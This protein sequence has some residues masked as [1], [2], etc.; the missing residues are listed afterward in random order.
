MEPKEE[1]G[2][3]GHDSETSQSK[4]ARDIL[5]WE[6]A[7]KSCRCLVFHLKVPLWPQSKHQ[8]YIHLKFSRKSTSSVDALHEWTFGV[9]V[10]RKTYYPSK[11]VKC[12]TQLK[13]L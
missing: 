12:R 8:L 13:C 11:S 1:Q 7:N 6:A 9:E 5:H 10:Q 3:G 2:A 4:A